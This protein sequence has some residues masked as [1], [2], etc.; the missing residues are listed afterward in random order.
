MIMD[1]PIVTEGILVKKDDIKKFVKKD[2][3]I[4]YKMSFFLRQEDQEHQVLTF[5]KKDCILLDNVRIQESIIVW[6]V[7][8]WNGKFIV[9]NFGFISI[10]T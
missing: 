9:E 5:N 1:L 4:G 7:K 6:W 8:L 10:G 2:G 3:T